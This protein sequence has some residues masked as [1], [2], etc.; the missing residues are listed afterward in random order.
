MQLVVVWTGAFQW[1]LAGILLP[2][3]E[4]DLAVGCLALTTLIRI[5]EHLHANSTHEIVVFLIL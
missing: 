1:A 4:A 5:I 3:V 2:S